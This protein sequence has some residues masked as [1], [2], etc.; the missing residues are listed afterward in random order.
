[1]RLHRPSSRRRIAVYV[2]A[3]A[4]ATTAVTVAVATTTSVSAQTTGSVASSVVT[5]DPTRV[6]DTRTAT[7]LPGPIAT[8]TNTSLRLTGAVPTRVGGTTGTDVV[9]QVIPTGATGALLNVT[10]LGP[11]TGGSLSIRP[12]TATGEPSSS[13]LNAAAGQVIPNAVTVNLPTTGP[14]AGTIDIW[15][16]TAAGTVATTGLLIDV[17]GYTTPAEA[18][19]VGPP[20]PK[21][22]P[23]D[24]GDPGIP[25]PPG[26]AGADG[27]DLYDRIIVVNG[28]LSAVEN[29]TALRSAVAASTG[30]TQTDPRAI[31]LEPGTYDIGTGSL[32]LPDDVSLLGSGRSNTTVTGSATDMLFVGD[33]ATVADVHLVGTTT[34]NNAAVL[35]V[36]EGVDVEVRSVAIT[37][38]GF[39]GSTGTH[40]VR[41]T[42]GS[43]RARIVD[44]VV[45]VAG[46]GVVVVASLDVV[47]ENSDVIGVATA[48]ALGGTGVTTVRITGSH[49]ENITGGN[50][51]Y[52]VVRV[53]NNTGTFTVDVR[54]STIVS[55]QSASF[56][57]TSGDVAG[58]TADTFRMYH[59]HVDVA[60]PFPALGNTTAHCSLLT[61]P[62]GSSF[63][64]C[65]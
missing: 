24:P 6:L 49:L 45:D 27:D 58:P 12:G 1:M 33:R 18:A 16:G 46:D 22:D 11:S 20:G 34:D 14:A 30:A 8:N 9:A 17:I 4:L 56:R 65:I 41:L 61:S 35:I 19:T 21:G 29:G 15:Y 31:Y 48:I 60:D 54:H 42:M 13:N 47:I 36:S 37:A 52:G 32:T 59:S 50:F 57:P 2:A 5:V 23:G 26:P 44:S 3:A 10:V 38:D 39:G 53:Y 55:A 43:H 7:G 63:D 62:A 25:G 64:T 40:G 28:D 51:D